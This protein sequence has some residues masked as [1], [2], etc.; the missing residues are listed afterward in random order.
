MWKEA[1]K[2]YDASG[3]NEPSMHDVHKY[4]E[5]KRRK[6]LYKE[7]AILEDV[8]VAECWTEGRLKNINV[9]TDDDGLCRRCGEAKESSMHRY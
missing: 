6:G 1:E 5:A 9:P 3:I 8:V 7:A 2:K 4:L